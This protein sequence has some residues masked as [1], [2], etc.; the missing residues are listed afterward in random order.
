MP[1]PNSFLTL[2][3]EPLA[4]PA[5]LEPNTPRIPKGTEKG[6][7]TSVTKFYLQSA[8]CCSEQVIVSEV[9]ISESF[10]IIQSAIEVLQPV[11]K[12]K[13]QV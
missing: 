6:G 5:K 9:S 12:A 4:L 11:L 8:R 1:F 3:H 13:L 10:L 7:R 2:Q